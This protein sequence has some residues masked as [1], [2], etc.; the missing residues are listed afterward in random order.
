MAIPPELRVEAL[1]AA[2]KLRSYE[3]TISDAADF[4]IKH[5]ETERIKAASSTVEKVAGL[6]VDA[7][8]SE[9]RKG[10]LRASSLRDISATANKLIKNWGEL[11]I[12]EL[13][14]SRFRKY[15]NSLTLSQRGL[16]NH[17]SLISQFFNWAKREN[18]IALNPVE[19]IQIKVIKND[20]QILSVDESAK[21]MGRAESDFPDLLAYHAVCLFAGLR[22]TE[23]E[24][25]DWKQID[26]SER[27]ITVLGETSKTKE[28][29][30]V[31]IEE[32][33]AHWLEAYKG[34]QKG[35]ILNPVNR[36]KRL[37]A[38]RIA[39][40][41][42]FRIAKKDINPD[43]P[44]WVS[45]ILRHSFASYWLPKYNDRPHLA[46]QMGN[47]IK[48]IKDHY[49]KVIPASE[50][51]RFWKILP[52]KVQETDQHEFDV[53]ESLLNDTREDKHHLVPFESGFSNLPEASP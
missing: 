34:E 12:A 52:K 9:K 43:G 8:A 30:N 48:M 37:Q 5:L 4:Y 53:I 51:A 28:T 7:K 31:K 46:E 45:D 44:E 35:F 16:F 21:L 24:L 23:A 42:K 32:T 1:K 2:T 47:S 40:G 20:I 36:R 18:L 29:R 22:P 3:K 15:F 41:F 14:E 25:L 6:W 49:K 19:N 11:K 50:V 38:F 33:L 17:R 10:I 26:L 39:L 13:T 27:Q